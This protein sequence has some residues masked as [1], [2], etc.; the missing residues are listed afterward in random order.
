MCNALRN[1]ERET[2]QNAKLRNELVFFL[3]FFLFF[4]VE[5]IFARRLYFS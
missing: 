1:L 2:L 3:S 4:D 5:Y